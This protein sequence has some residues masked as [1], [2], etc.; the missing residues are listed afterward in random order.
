MPYTKI[1]CQLDGFRL[2]SLIVTLTIFSIPLRCEPPIHFHIHRR[3]RMHFQRTKKSALHILFPTNNENNVMCLWIFVLIFFS[4]SLTVCAIN[5]CFFNAAVRSISW[6]NY[7]RNRSQGDK[8]WFHA[9]AVGP[10]LN[11]TRFICSKRA[12]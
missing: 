4:P 10:I 9:L 12:D 8:F 2:A 6:N 3:L 11:Q 7:L 1:S 5:W